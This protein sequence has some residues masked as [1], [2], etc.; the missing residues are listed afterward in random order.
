GSSGSS[1]RTVKALYDYKAKRSD[2]L[3]FCRGAL[4]HNV[5]KEPGGWWKGDYGT[6]IQQYFPSNYVEDIS[7]PSS[8]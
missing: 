8:G 7:G 1:G 3:T 6:R 4:I 2:E 5:S